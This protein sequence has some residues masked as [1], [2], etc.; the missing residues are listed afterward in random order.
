MTD[1]TVSLMRK[2]F[3]FLQSCISWKH[4]YIPAPIIKKIESF[5]ELPESDSPENSFDY[6]H[7][8]IGKFFEMSL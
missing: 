6:R 1:M 4:S 5:F 7:F 2:I 3:T 8:K